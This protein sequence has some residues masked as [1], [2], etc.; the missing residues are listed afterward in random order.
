MEVSGLGLQF[1]RTYRFGRTWWFAL[2][3]P[4]LLC[5]TVTRWVVQWGSVSVRI[6]LRRLLEP[7][8]TLV[9]GVYLA[10]LNINGNTIVKAKEDFMVKP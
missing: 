8:P 10:L 6:C 5:S 3:L 7:P 9:L 4:F 1:G 2:L